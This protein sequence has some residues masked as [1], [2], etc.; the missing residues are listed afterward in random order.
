MKEKGITLIALIITVIILLILAV[1]SIKIVT[2]EG[3]INQSKYIAEE[4]RASQVEE[5]RNLWAQEKEIAKYNGSTIKTLEELLTEMQIN[6]LITEEEKATIEETGQIIIGTKTITFFI[7]ENDSN[8][9]RNPGD[10]VMYSYDGTKENEE[11]WTILYDYGDSVEILCPRVLGELT[12]G[13]ADVAAASTSYNDAINLIN[14]YCESLVTN[15]NKISVR[16]VCSNPE[17]PESEEDYE[18]WSFSSYSGLD[19]GTDDNYVKDLNIM[20]TLGVSSTSDN[21][22]YWI[23]S[24]ESKVNDNTMGMYKFNM[25]YI[26]EDG[27]MD[28]TC[29]KWYYG[30]GGKQGNSVTYPVRPVVKINY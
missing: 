10:K 27:N 24:R 17:N 16:S 29:I 3:I 23:P 4:S 9:S 8:E 18:S 30:R 20:N 12:I 22:E 7:E 21:E 13:G 14:Q 15:K 6:K 11:E 5:Q 1:V 25:R 28:T 26:N 2:S 19:K